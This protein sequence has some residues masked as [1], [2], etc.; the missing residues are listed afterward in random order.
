VAPADGDSVLAV[1]AVDVNGQSAGF[2]SYGPSADGR[3]KPDVASVGWLAIVA[4]TL[5]NPGR[6]NGTSFSNP[7]IAGLVTCLWQAFPEFTN[8][9]ILDAVKRHSSHYTSPDDRVGYGI[10]NMRI[11]Y[12]YL[13]KEKTRRD[14]Q[15]TLGESYIKAY[16]VPFQ[17]SFTTL[18]KARGNGKVS[19]ELLDALGRRLLIKTLESTKQGE[20][21][22]IPFTGLEKLPGG[23]YFIR[24]IDDAGQGVIRVS[25]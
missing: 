25:K 13:L 1:G 7:N 22:Y 23:V 19:L 6:A 12:E 14:A 9:E 15:R 20:F 18:Y 24:H 21:Y 3:V 8:M 17:N 16:P 11:A 4:N 5:G 2:S 10:P